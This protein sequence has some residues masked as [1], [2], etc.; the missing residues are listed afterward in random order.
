M[1]FL[2]SLGIDIKLLVAQMINFGLLLWLLARFV[3]RPIIKR[4]EKDETELKQAQIQK[5]ELEQQRIV[6]TQKE[7]NEI[8]RAKQRA[9]E[10]IK[11]AEGIAQKI[12]DQARREAEQEKQAIIKQ[13]R[14]RLSE[15]EHAKNPKREK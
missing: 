7:K 9:R 10:I 5:K 15:I 12:K 13:I 2:G 4:I 14:S 3:Y 6:F 8:A 11:E 1:E